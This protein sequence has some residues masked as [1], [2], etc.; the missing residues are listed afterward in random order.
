MQLAQ[1]LVQKK[2]LSPADLARL[3][4][5]RAAAPT[6]PLHKLLIERGFAKEEDVLAAL[7]EELGIDLV[8]LTKITVDPETLKAMPLKLVHRRS[9]MPISRENGTI[10]VARSDPLN[11]NALDELQTITGLKVVPV[12]ASAREVSRPIK[13]HF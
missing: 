11:I 3:A 4:E 2:L 8:D 1:H 10:V 9:L 6:E 7:A 5:V 13:A 12:L